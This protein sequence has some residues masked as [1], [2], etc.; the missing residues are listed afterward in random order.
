MARFRTFNA[1][2]ST[3]VATRQLKDT[4]LGANWLVILKV[5]F[6]GEFMATVEIE[7]SNH[8]IASRFYAPTVVCTSCSHDVATLEGRS[9]KLVFANTT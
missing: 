3:F 4:V 5:A 1:L 9:S 8:G 7:F 6:D 2:L